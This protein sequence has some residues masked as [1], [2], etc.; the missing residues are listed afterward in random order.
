MARRSC[1]ERVTF[2]IAIMEI[3]DRLELIVAGVAV[4]EVRGASLSLLDPFG[5]RDRST[6]L[7]AGIIP[8]KSLEVIDG[9]VTGLRHGHNKLPLR[10]TVE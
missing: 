1:R 3:G 2:M 8:R 5:N 9:L 7:S 4:P 10:K 6:A